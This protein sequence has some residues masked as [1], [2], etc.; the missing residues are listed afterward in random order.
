MVILLGVEVLLLLGAAAL[1]VLVAGRGLPA[2]WAAGLTSDLGRA[3]LS[4]LGASFLFGAGFLSQV[5][6]DR[7]A[8]G[9]VVRRPG[10][11][12]EIAIAPQAIRQLAAG[13]LRQELALTDF[14]VALFPEGEGVHVRVRLPLPPDTEA[15]QLAEQIQTLLAREIEAKT[16]L[17]V[18]GVNLVLRGTVRAPAETG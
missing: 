1:A 10:S 6:A 18:H 13:L 17:A 7:L 2:G 12:G 9:R 5:L 11:K 15:P 16:G 8:A 3:V 14:R 4:L